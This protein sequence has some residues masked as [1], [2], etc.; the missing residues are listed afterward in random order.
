M[1]SRLSPRAPLAV[2]LRLAFIVVLAL[3][4]FAPLASAQDEP[5]APAP[6]K[7]P[8][9]VYIVQLSDAPVVLYRGG[10]A[11]LSGTAVAEGSRPDPNSADVQNY[12]AYLERRQD[13]VL[14]AIGGAEKLYSYT[15]VYNGFAARM[16]PEQAAAAARTPGVVAVTPD[17]IV[18]A[19][20]TTTPQFLGLDAA[21]GLWAQLGGPSRAGEG[22]IVGVI[23]S[24]IWP[25][26]ASFADDGNNRPLFRWNGTCLASGEEWDA[27]LCNGK[28]IGARYYNAGMGGDAGIDATRPWEYNSPRDYNSHGSHTASTSAGNY[29][30]PASAQG[31]SLGNTSGM[32][33]RAK[34]AVYKALWSLQDASQAS[35]T[36][37]D[38]VA[39]IN[40][41]TRDG[42]NVIN[43]SISGSQTSVADPAEQTFL[44]AA[45]AG[46][47]VSA[48]AG[49]SGPTASTV[50]HNSPWLTT[51]AAGTHDRGY[52]ATI[53]LGNAATYKG[54]SL[55]SGVG[56]APLILSTEAGAAGADP[57]AVRLCYSGSYLDPAKVAGKIVL[58]DRGTNARVDKSLAVQQAGGVGMILANVSPSS[59]NADIH[60]IPTIH[61]DEVA[62]AA[63]KAYV[64]TDPAAATATLGPSAVV[65]VEAPAVAS[66]S[67][68]GPARAIS[69]DLLKPDIMAPGV[70]VIASVSPS[71]GSFNFNFM[72]GT[73]MSAPHI[74]G[75]AALLKARQ[76]A[77]TPDMIK[78]A[79]MTTASQKTNWGNPLTGNPF[80]YGAGQVNP[81]AAIN[82]GLVYRASMQDYAAFMCGQGL[83][84]YLPNPNVCAIRKIA[85]TDLNLPSIAAG[86]L[87]GSLTVK[88]T[89]YNV[90]NK[91]LTMK[92][93]ASVP[94]MTVEVVPATITVRP[95]ASVSF[96]VKLTRT[97]AALNAYAFGALTWTGGGY[98]VR[99]PIA[100]RPVAIAAPGQVTGSGAAGSTS[101]DV[102]F[103]YNGDF[104]AAPRG[105]VAA[106]MF[107]GSIS[108]GER[109]SFSFVVPAG[110]KLARFSLF[111]AKVSK[112]SDLDLEVYRG[113]T[114]VGSSGG[115]TSEEE[116]NLT[117]P[118]AATYTIVVDG[119]DAGDS[120]STFTLYAWAVTADNAGNMTVS[121][122][123][124]AA[125]G[126]SGA[127]TLNWT[128]LAAGTKYLGQVT[129]HNVAAPA[130]YDDGRIGL[131]N[132]L[133]S[134]D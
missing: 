96:N 37:S 33:P 104:A 47:F 60:S 122:P 42:V 4:A 123:A 44:V 77:W 109:L 24:G 53:T 23:D 82:P 120:P 93:A 79:M 5:V 30:V 121:A 13:T 26:S 69:G 55:G 17:S 132:V 34:V 133:V 119:F 116:V 95:G 1:S 64:N 73:S 51:V 72:S 56:P 3:A 58:C 91:T 75:I 78:S 81:N 16:S 29:N 70:D 94:G 35:G 19:D 45:G 131:T 67:S 57:T 113:S 74:A 7:S 125:I 59:L 105:L 48:S 36:T 124:T 85:A 20:T 87:P 39:A 25:E 102:K 66:F 49:N 89:V 40:D 115:G 103:G 86:A 101:Y 130:G 107:D 114:L 32:A 76:P 118:T 11:G 111:D 15:Y 12:T 80:G 71:V 134:T 88:R 61:V 43:Y 62:G 128:G 6:A 90:T 65:K 110:T 2:A 54:V 38:L 18:Y 127:I 14:Q 46:V 97:T 112:P 98:T 27:S 41:A 84:A 9:G 52:E 129:Y 50:A 68:R 31:N 126:A 63:I 21:N 8:N 92:A 10:A 83:G 117:N 28:L 99:S 106:T 100:V 22:V 108:T